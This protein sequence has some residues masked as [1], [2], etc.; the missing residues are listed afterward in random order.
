MLV[1]AYIPGY[2]DNDLVWV[3]DGL[4]FNASVLAVGGDESADFLHGSDVLVQFR[5]IDLSLREEW[6]GRGGCPSL[7][8]TV[9][10]AQVARVLPEAPRARFALETAATTSLSR[11]FGSDSEEC[12]MRQLHAMS[13][14]KVLSHTQPL[15]WVT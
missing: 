10:L 5:V 9:A 1:R 2:I 3:I 11:D 14:T 15:R 13:V 12:A 6:G 7:S 8:L 4:L